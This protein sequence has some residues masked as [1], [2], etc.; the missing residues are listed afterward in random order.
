M[1]PPRWP[2]PV[3]SPARPTGRSRG[4]ARRYR[5]RPRRAG[6]SP[7]RCAGSEAARRRGARIRCARA[8]RSRSGSGV[9]ETSSNNDWFSCCGSGWSCSKNQCWI[10][11]S[12]TGPTTGPC[13]ASIVSTAL[14]HPGQLGDRLMSEDLTRLQAEPGLPGP[15]DDLDDEDRVDPQLEQ[16]LADA[17]RRPVQ[18]LRRRPGPASPRPGRSVRRSRP[19][20]PPPA[21]ARP[22][23][24]P[25]RWASAA[26]ASSTT[27]AD[28]TMNSGKRPG[29]VAPERLGLDRCTRLGVRRSR[30]A[31]DRRACPPGRSPPPRAR[32]D[33]ARSAAS[34]SPSSTR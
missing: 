7:T 15:R 32:P 28:G 17:D 4:T 34:T 31:V 22:C 16:V 13:S 25:C 19:R 18:H 33:D 21:P 30:R 29:Q 26:C 3:P 12:G 20:P 27:M 2:G 8:R 9:G 6:S 14:G 5:R 23:G 11:V 10:G 24:P 1:P